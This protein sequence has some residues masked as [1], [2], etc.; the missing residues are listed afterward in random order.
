MT[1][2]KTCIGFSTCPTQFISKN[3][4][5]LTVH[6]NDFSPRLHP[7]DSAVHMIHTITM[8]SMLTNMVVSLGLRAVVEDRV[9][10]QPLGVDEEE[11][12]AG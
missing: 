9:M 11:A 6:T 1:L 7:K 10:V 5:H 2:I 3:C 12:A 8:S 4:M